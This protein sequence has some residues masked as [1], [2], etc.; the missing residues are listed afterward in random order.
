MNEKDIRQVLLTQFVTWATS[1]NLSFAV[2]NI[3]FEPLVGNSYVH[4]HFIEN[5]P[6]STALAVGQEMFLGIMQVD[7]NIPQGEGEG[8][9]FT[10]YDS[11]KNIFKTNGYISNDKGTVRLGKVYLSGENS[12]NPW[13]T[14]YITVE[15]SA[16]ANN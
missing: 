3:E 6:I 2:S 4:L 11:F 16:F 8:E 12:E 9:I 7:I 13:H 14:K 1:Q 15:Y 5:Q 10:I